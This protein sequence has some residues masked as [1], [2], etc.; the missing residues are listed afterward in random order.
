M[1]SS[2]LLKIIG[3]LL[4]ALAFSSALTLL[5]EGRLTRA[6]LSDQALALVRSDL[7]VLRAAYLQREIA[8]IGSIRDLAQS[9]N[10]LAPAARARS[11]LVAELGRVQR[12]L[13]LDALMILAAGGRELAVVGASLSKPLPPGSAGAATSRLLPTSTGG[14]LQAAVFPI[15]DG[16][17][18]L[19]GGY[20]FGDAL[21]YQL[22]NQ[23]G[24]DVVLVAGGRIAGS[25]LATRL[26]RPPLY[27]NG[28]PLSGPRVARIGG[29]DTLVQYSLVGA[30]GT[31]NDGALG[32]VLPEPIAALDVSL[33][34]SRILGVAILVVV[35]VV[36]SWLLFRALTRPLVELTGTAGLIAGGDLDA[37]FEIASGD[38]IGVLA[39]ALE[40]MRLELRSKLAVIEHQAV[41]LQESSKRIAAATDEERHRVARDLHDGIQQSLTVLRMGLGMAQDQS[42]RDPVAAAR[43]FEE[44]GGE[45]DRIIEQLREVSQDLYPSILTDRGLTLALRSYAG[46]I[47]LAMKV[48][49]E[50][51]PLPRLEPE[52]ESSAYFLLSEA[53]TN[54]LKHAHAKELVIA[55]R[56]GDGWLEVSI[57]DDGRGFPPDGE[58]AGRGLTHMRDRVRS[59]AGELSIAAAPGRGT[60][61]RAT[62]PV[63]RPGEA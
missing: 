47:P 58:T 42:Q 59:F 35:A 53:V 50:P 12:N 1:R 22:R 55:L 63:R 16:S 40:R 56:L 31:E 54:A 8:L 32:V 20:L 7:D 52:V 17:L 29:V 6:Q 25:T 3:A 36:L 57:A 24:N 60:A 41:A 33:A 44:I 21:A 39:G 9:L 15:G 38:E 10:A 4:I 30:T 62:F 2:L 5:F 61:I 11:D 28:L 46:R 26:D 14:F 13:S 49:S 19:A 43:R 37:P 27:S 34:R 48:T 23:V 18:L 45:L 51:D